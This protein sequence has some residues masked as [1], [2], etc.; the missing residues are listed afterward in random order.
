MYLPNKIPRLFH[1]PLYSSEILCLSQNPRSLEIQE[2]LLQ[3]QKSY[4]KINTLK[5]WFDT[6]FRHLFLKFR[7]VT[8]NSQSVF[9]LIWVKQFNGTLLKQQK[10]FKFSVSVKFEGYI[11]LMKLCVF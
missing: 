11:L 4:I 5:F 1:V 10:Y 2:K 9:I 3:Q 8:E 6:T 7:D